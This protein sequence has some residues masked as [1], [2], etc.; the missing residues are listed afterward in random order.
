MSDF[1]CAKRL[2]ELL[3]HEQC[4]LLL[5]AEAGASGNLDRF[6]DADCNRILLQFQSH[7]A[8]KA[9]KRSATVSVSGQVCNT[10][11]ANL[12][13]SSHHLASKGYITWFEFPVAN[14]ESLLLPHAAATVM[15]ASSKCVCGLALQDPTIWS[16]MLLCP[17]HFPSFLYLM[18]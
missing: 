13:A 12:F 14:C 4:M 9:R 5:M 18:C 8:S 16:C 15:C 17:F 7:T 6:H 1:T 2:Y 3:F 10:D 11:S